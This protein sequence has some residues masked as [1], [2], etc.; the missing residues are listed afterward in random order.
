MFLT[1]KEIQSLFRPLRGHNKVARYP[2]TNLGVLEDDTLLIEVA[3]AGFDENDIELEVVGNEMIISGTKSESFEKENNLVE[4]FQQHISPENFSRILVL[5]KEYAQGTV[6]AKI[7]NG[8]LT[9]HVK[10]KEPQRKL[11]EIG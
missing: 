2:L 1:D 10:P 5:K 11:I 7:K 4:Y 6:K 9:I 3:V 8:I